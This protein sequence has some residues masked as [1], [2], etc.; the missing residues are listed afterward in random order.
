[1]MS[2]DTL[3]ERYERTMSSLEQMMRV[4]YQVKVQ[5]ECESETRTANTSHSAKESAT[6]A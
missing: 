2:G 3:V 4:G 5:W 6:Y 1:M